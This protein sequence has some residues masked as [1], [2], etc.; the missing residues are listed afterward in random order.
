TRATS[1]KRC[2]CDPRVPQ[3]PPTVRGPG[4]LDRTGQLPGPDRAGAGGDEVR[5]PRL[6]DGTDR[7]DL[8]RL[9]IRPADPIHATNQKGEILCVPGYPP[10]S[11]P[12]W[13]PS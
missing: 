12:E 5:H 6:G 13:Q 7:I 8:G 9:P 2:S 10:L 11:A 4:L 3:P 1:A